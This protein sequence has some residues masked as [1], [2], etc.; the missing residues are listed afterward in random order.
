MYN[1]RR[2]NL[3]RELVISQH[4]LKDQ[5]TV[6]GLVWSFLHP[7]LYLLVLF[8]FFHTRM[9]GEIEHYAIYLLIGLIHYTHL[10]NTTGS[11]LKILRSRRELTAE[12]LFPKELLVFS[13][14]IGISLEF[15]VSMAICLGFA[16]AAGVSPSWAW[17]WTP[18]VMALQLVLV[19]W[20]GLVLAALYAFAWDV[21]H[22]YQVLLRILFFATPIFYDVSFLGDGLARQVV[23][24]NPLVHLLDLARGVILGGTA[25]PLWTLSGFLAANL[26]LAVIALRFFRRL[27]PR[28][29]ENV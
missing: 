24:L 7:L 11:A 16:V 21:D 25:P 12:A 15:V 26:V 5:S 6:L 13:T 18:V 23:L 2:L 3:L 1:R 20:I 28:F 19:T 29:A 8:I 17:L 22:I 27:E 9:G 10:S 14:V 4:K